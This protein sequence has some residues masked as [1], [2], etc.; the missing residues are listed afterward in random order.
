VNVAV[1]LVFVA[2]AGIAIAL[3][4]WPSTVGAMIVAW[5]LWR[6]HRR[7]R[8]AAYIFLSMLTV[9]AVVTRTWPLALF[10]LVLIAALQLPGAHR[11]WPR[12]RWGRPRS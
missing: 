9:R 11:L 8:F 2:Y 5:L 7:A 6:Q 1:P 3:G 10:A 4:R 12:L